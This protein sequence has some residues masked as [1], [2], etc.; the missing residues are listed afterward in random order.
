MHSAELIAVRLSQRRLRERKG[1]GG[2]SGN[3]WR[4]HHDL[5]PGQN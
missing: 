2:R 5:A 4:F 1:Y 3:E